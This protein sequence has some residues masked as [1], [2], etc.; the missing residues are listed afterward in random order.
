MI[1]ISKEPDTFHNSIMEQCCFCDIETQF[2]H[3]DTNMPCCPICSKIRT[4]KEIQVKR[5]E[6]LAEYA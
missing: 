2:W 3:L 6:L 4:V 5:N 1:P